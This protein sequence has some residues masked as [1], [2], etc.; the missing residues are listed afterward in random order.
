MTTEEVLSQYPIKPLFVSQITVGL[1]NE[2][3]KVS[4]MEGDFILQRLNNIYDLRTIINV[5]LIGKFLENQK[6]LAQQTVW[7]KRGECG[8]KEGERW[9]RLLTFIPGRVVEKIDCPKL[10]YEAG[11][12]FGRFHVAM[13]NYNWVL[14]ETPRV[15]DTRLHWKKFKKAI[16]KENGPE[17]EE[18]IKVIGHL[19]KLLLPTD[20]EP[21]ITHGDP[22]ISNIVFGEPDNQAK[23]L[24]DLDGCSKQNSVLVE[25][26]DAFRSWCASFEDDPNNCF[27]LE[28]FKNVWTGYLENASAMVPPEER[29]LVVQAIKL[30]ILELA[31]RF[32]R[33]Y[34]EDCYF[35]WDKSRYPCRKAHNLARAKGQVTL[36][37]N[38]LEKESEV[39]EIIKNS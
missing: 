26:G 10:A 38:F 5:A 23:A 22:K 36:Y 16:P 12:I 2:T 30:I 13:K 8:V 15:H 4:A 3:F 21:A 35:G 39:A 20:L 29:L 34:F 32:L 14:H 6:F 24:L 25:L 11:R 18:M 19:P 27:D 31:S 7:T 37:L 33:D 17:I 9:W 28:K 1:I